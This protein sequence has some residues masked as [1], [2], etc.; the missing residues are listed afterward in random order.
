MS[1]DA[2]VAGGGHN[3]LVCAA[4]LARAGRRV[5]VVERRE[6]T[7]GI[8]DGVVST[9]GRLRPALVAELELERHGLELARP[10]IRML[11]L[12]EGGAPVAFWADP[13][14]TAE[15]LA[16]VSG[17]DATAYPR[18]DAHVRVL[19]RFLGELAEITPPRLDAGALGDWQAGLRLARAYRRLDSRSARELTRA[20]PMAAADFVGEW[21]ATDAVRAAL[22]ARGS[23]FTAMGPWSAG[24]T[25]VLL[26]DS[27]GN[28]GGAAG[29]TAFA[30]SGPAALAAAI[31]SAAT[32][33][34]ATIRTRAEVARVL[35]RGGR[36]HGVALASGEEI[37]APVVACG[38]DPKTVLTRWLDPEEA[39][40]RL[41]WRAGNIRTPGATAVVDLRLSGPPAFSGVDDPQLLAGRIVVAPGIDHVERAFDCWKYGGL[42]ERPYLEATISDGSMHVLAQWVPHDAD[43]DAVGDLV[44]AELERHAPGIGNS[45]ADRRVLTPALIERD[46]GLSGGH[47][48]H[49]E[50]GLDQFFAWRPVLGLARYRLAVPGLYLCGSGAHPGG[51]VTGGPGQNAAREILAD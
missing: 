24:T 28:D 50:P 37:E 36:V 48:Y 21:F 10:P 12:R 33:A 40:P 3:G 25:A 32:A 6:R 34:G 1:Y 16:A 2:I 7:G 38:V 20:L 23:L 4:L 22:A 11:A 42:S 18:F 31:E 41:R 8:L 5:L 15:G 30:T 17:A 35:V 49:A 47:V 45:V 46:F 19:A 27:A 51:G 39:G 9:V 29:Q 43:P 44:V 13:G 26:A 14:R